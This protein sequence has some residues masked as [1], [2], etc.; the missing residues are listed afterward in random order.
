M[1]ATLDAG[2]KGTGFLSEK[3]KIRAGTDVGYS[4]HK[5]AR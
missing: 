4:T 5:F 2:E 3:S 1:K